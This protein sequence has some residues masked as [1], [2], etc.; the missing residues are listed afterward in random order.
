M[1]AYYEVSL[2]PEHLP[3]LIQARVHYS[4][5]FFSCYNTRTGLMVQKSFDYRPE[6][7]GLRAIAVLAVIF[8]HAGFDWIPGGFAGVDVFFVISGYLITQLIFRQKTDEQFS[9]LEFYERR[10][11][12]LLPALF[13]VFAACL[14]PATIF[15]LPA[16]LKDF[17]GSMASSAAFAGN[18]YFW[19]SNTNGYFSAT[20]DELPLLHLWSLGV[21]EQFYFF[22]PLILIFLMSFAR[23]YLM[24]TVAAGFLAS[25][26]LYVVAIQYAPSASFFLLP[27]RGWELLA[28]AL[29]A[30]SESRRAE[31]FHKPAIHFD[32]MSHLMSIAGLIMIAT[33]FFLFDSDAHYSSFTI[34]PIIFGTALF[35][36]F[37]SG[38]K[39]VGQL[40]AGRAPVAIGLI[41]YSAYLVHQPVFAFAKAV[42]LNSLTLWDRVFLLIASLVVSAAIWRFIEQ[43]FRDRTFLTRKVVF[44]LSGTLTGLFLTIGGALWIANG[45]PDRL[46]KE[47]QELAELGAVNAKEMEQCFFPAGA[48]KPLGKGC[49]LNEEGPITTAVVGDSHALAIAPAIKEFL[50]KNREKALLFTAAGCPPTLDASLLGKLQNHCAAFNR[51]VIQFIV[52]D[53]TIRNVIVHA[54][55]A[56]YTERQFFENQEGGVEE[57]PLDQWDRKHDPKALAAGY[58][59]VVKKLLAAKKN[60]ILIYPV[61]EVGWDVPKYLVK[62]ELRVIKD[63]L[64]VTTS[65]GVF[66]KRNRASYLILDAVGKHPLLKRVYPAARLCNTDIKERCLLH[67]NSKPLYFDDDHLSE[68]GAIFALPNL[69]SHLR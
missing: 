57:G 53:R 30:L 69:G 7:D 20:A 32:I 44:G 36:R 60:V 41:S 17:G 33:P 56:Y 34:I 11:R 39:G 37:A 43:P 24:W 16:E 48:D 2:R 42:S 26:F 1:W 49:V 66:R 50:S 65:Y 62:S 52:E 5:I 45:W 8:Y 21:E 46:T 58:R 38:S 25:F 29:V 18:I 14:I 19:L 3:I 64:P 4:E 35:I 47:S 54:R 10:M 55:W 51:K 6:I 15:M 61:P 31:T 68:Y 67:I 22:Y 63:R 28:G 59:K 9:I 12:R 27:T 23:Y 40:L 13:V